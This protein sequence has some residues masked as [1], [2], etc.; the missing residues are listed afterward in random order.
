MWICW[1]QLL[2]NWQRVCFFN[3]DVVK[4]YAIAGNEESMM[5]FKFDG[6]DANKN[7]KNFLLAFHNC[8]KACQE[9]RNLVSVDVGGGDH[10]K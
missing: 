4:I 8:V 1:M 10:S 2:K 7:R 9:S 6:Y 5:Q 3:L